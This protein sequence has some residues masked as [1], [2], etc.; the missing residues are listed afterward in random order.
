MDHSP[1]KSGGGAASGLAM[2]A[3]MM[4]CCLGV[5]LLVLLI[6]VVGWPVGISIVAI[7]AVAMLLFHQRFMR[8][9]HR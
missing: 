8:H 9:G 7:G 3:L 4:V 5:V 6:P 1:N 2:M